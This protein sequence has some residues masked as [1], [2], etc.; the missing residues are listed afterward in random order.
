MS[1][2]AV[3]DSQIHITNLR[4]YF[5]QI[6]ARWDGIL[7]EKMMTARLREIVA[8]LSIEPRAAVLDV[9]CGTGVLFPML[10]EKVGRDGHIVALD[11][12]GKMFK[13]AKTKGYPVTYIQGDAQ[14]LPFPAKTFDWVLCNAV[15]PHFSDKLGALREI[16]R[17]LKDGGR[18][19]ICHADS[20]EAVN[21]IHRTIGGVVA[22]DTI[23]PEEETRRLLRDAKLNHAVV[24]NEPDRYM[25]MA[26]RQP[27]EVFS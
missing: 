14:W 17:V 23:P 8:G 21:E 3:S 7:E 1:C 27:S 20:R 11:I 12:S 26:H 6:A 19:V 9:G 22:C 24:R 15:F 16:H 18:L 4:E 2:Q 5:D 25:V 10:L 13:R